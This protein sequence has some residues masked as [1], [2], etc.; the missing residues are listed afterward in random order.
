MAVCFATYQFGDSVA[1]IGTPAAVDAVAEELL[2]QNRQCRTPYNVRV[3]HADLTNRDCE[4][5]VCRL[6][7]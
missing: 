2:R 7:E 6:A 5:Y 1:Y 3:T 4:G